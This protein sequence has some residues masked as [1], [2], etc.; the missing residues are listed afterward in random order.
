MECFGEWLVGE[1]DAFGFE[2]YFIDDV[3]TSGIHLGGSAIFLVSGKR[4]YI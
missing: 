4:A 2:E 3:G 1:D